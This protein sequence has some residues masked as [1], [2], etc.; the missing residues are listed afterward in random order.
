[1]ST[2]GRR[3]RAGQA[4]QTRALILATAE[5]LFAEHG[6]H[7]VSN[8]QIGEAA[9]QANNAAVA[10]HFG[11]KTDLVRAIIRRHSVPTERIRRRLL[12]VHS[13]SSDLRDWVTCVV[14]P[15]TDH[16]IDLGH[17]SWY[18]RFSAQLMTEPALLEV[19]AEEFQNASGF[20]AVIDGLQRCVPDLPEEVRQERTHM[21]HTLLVHF[22]AQRERDAA[23]GWEATAAGLID[24]IVGMFTAPVT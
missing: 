23:P 14:R 11:T 3:G 21:A 4:E 2:G 13:G 8:R 9:G 19:A 12:A 15:I 1:M 24:A 6:V 5:R 10:Y 7:A 18:A 22:C 20:L 16:L 17:P